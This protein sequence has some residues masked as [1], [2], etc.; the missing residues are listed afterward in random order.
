M[1]AA[2]TQGTGGTAELRAWVQC[3][4]WA[5]VG[6]MSG[7]GMLLWGLWRRLRACGGVS[8]FSSAV[9][10]V[11]RC[12]GTGERSRAEIGANWVRVLAWVA[13]V[14]GRRYGIRTPAH[15]RAF[16]G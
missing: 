14:L 8:R 5:G 10:T 11:D 1:S 2:Y 12:H 7:V 13:L 9:G 6:A 15:G 16:F 3:G 4:T